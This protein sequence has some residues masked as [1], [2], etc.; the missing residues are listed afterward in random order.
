MINKLTNKNFVEL[1]SS[2]NEDFRQV[3]VARRN[4]TNTMQLLHSFRSVPQRA[5]ELIEILRTDKS[6]IK[7]VY[8]GSCSD[9]LVLKRIL[10]WSLS[11]VIFFFLLFFFATDNSTSFSF[12]FLFPPLD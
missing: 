2:I 9:D 8:R 6:K 7:I 10:C 4:V 1:I 3:N 11:F 5:S 12:L